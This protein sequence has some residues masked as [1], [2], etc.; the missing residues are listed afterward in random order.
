MQS[1][2]RSDQNE[3]AG[4]SLVA[5]SFP[6][7]HSQLLDSRASSSRVSWQATRG[8]ALCKDVYTHQGW[9]SWSGA[10]TK[11]ALVKFARDPDGL[12]VHMRLRCGRVYAVLSENSSP[13]E[14]HEGMVL[15]PGARLYDQ[16]FYPYSC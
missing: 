6:D 9:T 10:A 8:Y 2:L 13:S 16:P 15:E 5:F 11:G 14:K 4:K 7:D 1:L 3:D 12:C